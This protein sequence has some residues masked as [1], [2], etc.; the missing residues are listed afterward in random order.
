MAVL[1]YGRYS[2][3]YISEAEVPAGHLQRPDGLGRDLSV[4]ICGSVREGWSE[5][6]VKIHELFK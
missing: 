1:L 6:R 4:E 3:K 2:L 5:G